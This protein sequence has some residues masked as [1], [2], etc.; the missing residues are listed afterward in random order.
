[1]PKRLMEDDGSPSKS[2]KVSALKQG[3][4]IDHLTR[5]TGLRAINV[6]GLQNE[7]GTVT[8][9]LNLESR[10]QGAKDLIKIEN[11]ELSQEEVN[12]IAL[13]SPGATF[14]IIRDFQVVE[15]IHPEL[16]EMV[17]GIVKCTNPSCVT[18]HFSDVSSKFLVVQKQPILLRCFYCE[19]T[20]KRREID[21]V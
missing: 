15:K 5:G 11:R 19:R 16:P 1:M 17:E 10:R 3:T 13:I 7:K 21:L 9:G 8:I 14:S 2:I 20:F 4:V 18:N 12:K 6:L